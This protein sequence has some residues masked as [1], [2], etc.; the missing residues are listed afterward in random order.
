MNPSDC[1][2]IE[3][4]VRT[5]LGCKCTDEVFDAKLYNRYRLVIASDHPTQLLAEAKTRFETAAGDDPRAHLHILATDQ[6]PGA[7]RLH[8]DTET[9][10]RPGR[11]L[12]ASRSTPT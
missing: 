4:F 11:E 1:L 10:D 5:T 3:H 7:I 12:S 2:S 6:L 8:V 9:G